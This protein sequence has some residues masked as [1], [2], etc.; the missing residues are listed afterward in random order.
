MGRAAATVRQPHRVERT[1]RVILYGRRAWIVLWKDLLLERRSKESLLIP[2][3]EGRDKPHVGQRVME[4]RPHER[5]PTEA[6]P[7]K[8]KVNGQAIKTHDFSPAAQEQIRNS[9]ER[10]PKHA[11]RSMRRTKK[12]QLLPLRATSISRG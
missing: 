3:P 7:A 2:E 1:N 4:Q 8:V 6:L 5:K 10:A 9:L 11:R 12:H